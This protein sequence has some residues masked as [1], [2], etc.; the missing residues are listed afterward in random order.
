MLM[1][2]TRSINI[3]APLGMHS[4]HAYHS[5]PDMVVYIMA[6]VPKLS[7]YK[8]INCPF[9]YAEEYPTLIS[10]AIQKINKDNNPILRL[11]C[12]QRDTIRSNY[13]LRG[14]F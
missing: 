14:K 10:K 7:K 11:L 8:V 9:I 4:I 13:T 5:A 3:L 6:Q 12:K 2:N 1:D